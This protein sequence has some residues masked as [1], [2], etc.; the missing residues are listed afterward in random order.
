MQ[1]HRS[2][3]FLCVCPLF[4]VT[5]IDCLTRF[6]DAFAARLQILAHLVSQ[7][8]TLVPHPV[9]VLAQG[10]CTLALCNVILALALLVQLPSISAAIVGKKSKLLGALIS[11]HSQTR[12][13]PDLAMSEAVDRPVASPCPAAIQLTLVQRLVTEELAQN[14]K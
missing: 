2:S 12:A 7:P 8:P 6:I 13:S 3:F 9:P 4:L 14:V 5:G 1:T 10:A 11:A